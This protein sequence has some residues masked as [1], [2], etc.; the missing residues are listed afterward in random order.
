VHLHGRWDAREESRV[1][2]FEESIHIGGVCLSV[3]EINLDVDYLR[4]L[5]AP[6]FD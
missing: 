5:L 6:T 3:Y 4:V 1:E 2:I